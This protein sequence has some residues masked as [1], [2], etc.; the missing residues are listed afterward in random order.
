MSISPG[1]I[2]TGLF[3]GASFHYFEVLSARHM[4]NSFLILFQTKSDFWENEVAVVPTH[5]FRLLPPSVPP[6]LT[7]NESWFSFFFFQVMF[8]KSLDTVR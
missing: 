5:C 3:H 8:D 7:A 4:S 1:T 6:L 2:I